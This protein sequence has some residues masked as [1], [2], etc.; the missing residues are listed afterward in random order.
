MAW[1]HIIST[2]A[3]QGGSSPL[4]TSAINT[5]GADIL[6]AAINVFQGSGLGTFSDSNINTWLPVQTQ[7]D[8]TNSRQELEVLYCKTPIVGAGHTFSTTASNFG[9]IS[10]S[11]FSG[12][13]TSAAQLDQ[14]NSGIQAGNG[15]VTTDQDGSITPGQNNEL[16]YYAVAIDGTTLGATPT[17]N[18][19]FTVDNFF[20]VQAG[21]IFGQ[22]T[23]YLFQSSK[24]AISPTLTRANAIPNGNTDVMVIVSFK[25][26]A[27]ASTVVNRRTLSPIGTRVGSRQ[28]QNRWKRSSRGGLLLRDPLILPEAA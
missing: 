27:V 13:L 3:G 24:A 26:A 12:S 2:V 22:C 14:K 16:I 20:D 6:I 17:V 7:T 21:A 10:V 28:V 5:T 9:C 11:A 15:S 23:S 8:T 18:D 4:T 19:G 1:S 25:G